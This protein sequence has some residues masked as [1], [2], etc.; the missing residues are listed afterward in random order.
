MTLYGK[1]YLFKVFHRYF[2]TMQEA[3]QYC[4]ECDF[5]EEYIQAEL[6]EEA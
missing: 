6:I 3:V 4:L 2:D 5:S 1:K